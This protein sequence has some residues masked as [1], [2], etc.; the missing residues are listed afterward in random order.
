MKRETMEGT[1]ETGDKLPCKIYPHFH[2]WQLYG[3]DIPNAKDKTHK[4]LRV[5]APEYLLG[6]NLASTSIICT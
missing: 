5:K 6:K 3:L 2:G 1:E 4:Q